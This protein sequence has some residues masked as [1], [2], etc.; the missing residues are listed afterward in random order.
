MAADDPIPKLIKQ[1]DASDRELRIEAAVQLGRLRD[2]RAVEALLQRTGDKR[3]EVQGAVAE[4]L[5]LIGDMRALDTLL[6][7]YRGDTYKLIESEGAPHQYDAIVGGASVALAQLYRQY[8]KPEIL[9]ILLN[10]LHRDRAKHDDVSIECT[11][12]ALAYTG[13][14][15]VAPILL[16]MA[17]VG[18]ERLRCCALEG[19]GRL[20]TPEGLPLLF[21]A[22]RLGKPLT[23]VWAAADGLAAFAY[24]DA[25][26]PLLYGLQRLEV[27]SFPKDH[28]WYLARIKIV[29]ALGI[30]GTSTARLGLEQRL[31]SDK[32]DQKLLGAIGLAYCQDKQA[33]L[34]L[35]KGLSDG[36]VW[37]R[38]EVATA[39]GALGD[40]KAIPVLEARLGS[41]NSLTS[42]EVDAIRAALAQ[43][44]QPEI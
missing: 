32:V 3:W 42:R 10:R 38:P 20:A 5:G 34:I 22:V 15:Q 2:T 8:H 33:Y 25:V 43:L 6:K 14:Q 37:T 18:S 29:R 30:I 23:L 40:P 27:N 1:L 9:E 7:M 12:R 19:L 11:L 16:E 44:H 31:N 36:D 17:Q 41:R 24:P 28:L 26:E 13:D 39:L 4:A 35:I 21:R